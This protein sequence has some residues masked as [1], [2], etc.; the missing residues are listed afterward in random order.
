[1]AGLSDALRDIVQ[2]CSGLKIPCAI[3]G[4]MAVRV[5]G[6][7]RPTHDIDVTIQIERDRLADLYD[8]LERCG[9]SV[10]E[11]FRSGWVDSVAGMPLVKARIHHEAQSVDIDIFL[12]ES[13]FQDSLIERRQITQVGEIRA[14]VV[15]PEDLVLLKLLAGRPRDIAD[16]GDIL[17]TQGELDT[18][19]LRKWA[20]ELGVVAE[21]D[22]ALA[23]GE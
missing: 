4:G 14:E 20:N 23:E 5:H 16:V 10:P 7:P 21:L 2:I 6:I 9:Y 19:Y 11:A 1:M 12:A 13:E 18:V 3:M 22:R 8:A 17:F 15:S